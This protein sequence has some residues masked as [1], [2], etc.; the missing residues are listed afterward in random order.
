MPYGSLYTGKSGFYYK[1]HAG[2][3]NARSGVNV[4]YV[5][6]TLFNSFVNGSGVGARNKFIQRAQIRAMMRHSRCV[7]QKMK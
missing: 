6:T 3:G 7:Y 5:D 2:G 4:P 1:K